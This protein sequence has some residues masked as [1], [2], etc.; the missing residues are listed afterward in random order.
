MGAG[1]R[2]QPAAPAWIGRQ[3][4]IDFAFLQIARQQLTLDQSIALFK[5]L[6]ELLPQGIHA[7][8]E[9]GALFRRQPANRAK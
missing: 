5:C 6:V 3:A 7:L 2:V 1:G 8:P 4:D 9:A